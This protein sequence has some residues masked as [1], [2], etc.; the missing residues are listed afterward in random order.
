[1]LNIALMTVVQL[2]RCSDESHKH[3]ILFFS[4]WSVLLYVKEMIK[5]WFIVMYKGARL[6]V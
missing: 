4:R 5:F 3:Q 6:G 1:M 2:M